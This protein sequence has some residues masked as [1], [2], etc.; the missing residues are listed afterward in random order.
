VERGT[1]RTTTRDQADRVPGKT[2]ADFTLEAAC[3]EAEDVLLD[4]IS[5][6]LDQETFDRF[7]ALLDNPPPPSEQLR[8]LLVS[9]VPWE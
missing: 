9:K 7:N 4:R 6:L 1:S 3:R 5:F 8:A 2:R